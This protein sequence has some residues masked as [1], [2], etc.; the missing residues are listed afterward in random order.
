MDAANSFGRGTPAGNAIFRL[1][2]KKNMDSTLDPELL[3]RLQKMRKER[4]E[5]EA[6]MVKPKVIP[7]SQAPI[8]VPKFGRR[9]SPSAEQIALMKLERMGHRKRL[10]DIQE[11]V[12]AQPGPAI[13]CPAKPAITDADKDRL[14]QIFQFGEA[15]P[16][17]PTELTGANALRHKKVSATERL[18]RRFDELADLLQEK[19][20]YLAEVKKGVVGGK[21]TAD[22]RQTELIV[23]NEIKSMIEE[24][25][26]IDLELKLQ[27]ETPRSE[28]GK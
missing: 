19:K 21:N 22:R 4:E 28:R 26:S 12:A 3:A 27:P 15:L 16:N 8:N 10:E 20:E 2:N 5:A 23:T 14:V 11:D 1:Y 24:M 18:E 6:S 25:K 7:K 13:P 17:Q 9:A